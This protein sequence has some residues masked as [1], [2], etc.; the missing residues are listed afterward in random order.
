LKG[1]E[2][3][4]LNGTSPRSHT[5]GM[6]GD[7]DRVLDQTRR[8]S[9]FCRTSFGLEAAAGRQGVDLTASVSSAGKPAKSGAAIHLICPGLVISEQYVD[10]PSA[11]K[12]T[13]G[14]RTGSNRRRLL[15]EVEALYNA[16]GRSKC[17]AGLVVINP[18][19]AVMHAREAPIM[20]LSR[21]EGRGT[22]T[23]KLQVYVDCWSRKHYVPPNGRGW[24]SQIR[25]FAG[26]EDQITGDSSD[27]A[28]S[29]GADRFVSRRLLMESSSTKFPCAVAPAH[30]HRSR[31][32]SFE[33]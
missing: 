12:P 23:R 21:R 24:V 28:D 31:A 11:D 33:S 14:N 26:N 10:P 32:R 8:A 5:F 15:P 4:N 30:G 9:L 25:R 2:G 22:R 7:T 16:G 19:P 3:R 6:S 17:M 27:R 18:P 29:G 13:P 20:H 1:E